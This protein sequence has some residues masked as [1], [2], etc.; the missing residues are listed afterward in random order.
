MA[1]GVSMTR[2][3]AP[4]LLGWCQLDLEMV[5]ALLVGGIASRD[6]LGFSPR[7]N[8]LLDEDEV[9]LSGDGNSDGVVSSEITTTDLNDASGCISSL[10]PLADLIQKGRHG[11]GLVDQATEV[12]TDNGAL[13]AVQSD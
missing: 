3:E 4:G 5:K 12:E 7:L 9:V 13:E 1:M 8:R 10:G 11:I 2:E 6:T